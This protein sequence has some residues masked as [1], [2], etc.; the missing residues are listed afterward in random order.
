[1]HDPPRSESGCRCRIRD[2]LFKA[3]PVCL[4][5]RQRP[6]SE[7]RAADEGADGGRG[8]VRGAGLPGQQ[9]QPGRL[10]HHDSRL[11]HND[12]V[13][14]DRLLAGREARAG[15]TDC[16]RGQSETEDQVVKP[17]TRRRAAEINC[18]AGTNLKV[19]GG[20]R[21]GAKCRQK[22][23]FGRAPPLFLA[24]KVQLVV[25]VSAFVMVSTVWSV[26]FLLFFYSRCPP[27]FQPF[28][29]VRGHVPPVPHGVSVTGNKVQDRTINGDLENCQKAI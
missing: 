21:S 22:N 11:P 9:P 20:H 23:F 27:R 4:C 29:K 14:A 6:L 19:E 13:L 25:L 1:M 10:R 5:G 15:R 8:A 2:H 12:Q 3:P 24:L 7:Q 17:S 16:H 28:V 26:S 18:G